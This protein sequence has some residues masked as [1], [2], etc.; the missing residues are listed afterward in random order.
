[1]DS[2]PSSPVAVLAADHAARV[3]TKSGTCSAYFAG[4]IAR[5]QIHLVL[6]LLD[7]LHIQRGAKQVRRG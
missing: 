1:M 7:D 2:E 3:L 4:Q 5:E 6:T